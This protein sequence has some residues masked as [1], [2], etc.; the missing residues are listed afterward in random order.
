MK[1]AIY[2]AGS[3]GN[4]ILSLIKSGNTISQ[5]EEIVFVDDI[6]EVRMVNGI[7]VYG[8]SEFKK[9][10]KKEEIKL[11]IA[12]GEPQYRKILYDKIIE[13][14][15]TL[16]KIISSQSYIGTQ[17]NI[18]DGT[19]VFPNV[20]ISNNVNIW[21]NCLIHANSKIESQCIIGAHSFVSSGAFIGANSKL[22]NIVF[23]GPNAALFDHID[24]GD[25]SLIGMGSVVIGD[26]SSNVVFAGN[27]AK[28][29]KDN[30]KGRVFNE[31]NCSV[32]VAINQ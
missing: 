4:E 29:I 13:D 25:N 10:Y 5:Y 19:V 30:I 11:V 32:G 3:L 6:C 16:E 20:Y 24:V 27:P 31:K 7:D 14:G 9:L 28:K 15:Y 21:E 12:S 22:G 1:I 2:G 8:Y 18:G 26:V 17:S 23:V